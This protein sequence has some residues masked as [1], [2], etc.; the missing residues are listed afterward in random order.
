ML[1][2]RALIRSALGCG[3]WTAWRGDKKLSAHDLNIG[4][5][6][7]DVSLGNV[8]MRQKL[9]R[10][11]EVAP[12]AVHRH[13]EHRTH[14]DPRVPLSDQGIEYDRFETDEVVLKPGDFLLGFARER[15]DCTKPLEIELGR[16]KDC[17]SIE[18][19]F[20]FT[21]HYDGRSTMGRL[22][23]LS[24]VTAGYGDYGFT[25]NFTL[26]L[27]NVGELPVILY[28]GMRIGQVSFHGILGSL[29]G[30]PTMYSGAYQRQENE[31]VAPVLGRERFACPG[32]T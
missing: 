9:T 20:V 21:Q 15:F 23:I 4:P 24:H 29:F 7:V 31:P 26:E 14:I 32:E 17:G 22:G 30:T 1:A 6:S 16:G 12:F 10:K 8:F 27:A 13:P 3:D 5:H 19:N 2:S 25:G 18:S 28:A 11:P